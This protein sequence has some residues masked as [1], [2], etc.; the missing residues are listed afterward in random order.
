MYI[1]YY[2]IN[3]YYINAGPIDGRGSL[4]NGSWLKPSSF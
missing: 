4:G 3:Y 2:I 1:I